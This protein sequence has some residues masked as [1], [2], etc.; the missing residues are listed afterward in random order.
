MRALRGRD[1]RRDIWL[2]GQ[3]SRS[4]KTIDRSTHSTIRAVSRKQMPQG[5]D[6]NSFAN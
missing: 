3:A 4:P 5:V 6:G 1:G 2:V